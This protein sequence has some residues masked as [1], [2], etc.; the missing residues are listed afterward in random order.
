MAHFAEIDA[1]FVVQRVLVVPDAEEHRGDDYLANQ[2]RLGGTWIQ[3]SYNNKIRKQ[4]AGI[5]FTYDPVADVFIQ[6]KP[7]P[8]WRLNSTFDWEAP[9]PKPEDA[10]ND[11]YWDENR[12]AWVT[13]NDLPT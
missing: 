8:S 2:L 12:L 10:T 11:T 4:Y 5:G 1:N 13:P 3:T 9:I 7:F 6:P